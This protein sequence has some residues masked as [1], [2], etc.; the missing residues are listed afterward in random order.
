MKNTQVFNISLNNME[1]AFEKMRHEAGWDTNEKMYWGYY[2]LDHDNEKLER[3]A[4][5]MQKEDYQIIEIR[6]TVNDNLYILHAEK[7]MEHSSQTLFEECHKLAKLAN[8]NNIE[9]FDGWD[10]ANIDQSKGLVE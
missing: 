10:V 8:E 4:K 1:A 6:S 5:T 9:I 7:H 3:F 2:F